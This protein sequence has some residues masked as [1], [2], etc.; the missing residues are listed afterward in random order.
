MTIDDY[1]NVYHLWSLA[2]GI[3][4]RKLYDSKE[5]TAIFLKRN[6][7]TNFV[8]EIDGELVGVI[9][10]GHDGRKGFIYHNVVKEE[11]RNR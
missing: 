9:L 2:E 6:P 4:L 10:C 5:G 8:C 7:N 3:S 11:F 1:E